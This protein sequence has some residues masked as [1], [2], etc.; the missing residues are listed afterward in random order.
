MITVYAAL[1][2]GGYVWAKYGLTPD[3]SSWDRVK[4][5]LVVRA[6]R[7]K[8]A[9]KI[10]QQNLD[11]VRAISRLEPGIRICTMAKMPQPITGE[12][13][14]RAEPA[15]AQRF[16]IHQFGETDCYSLPRRI[17]AMTRGLRLPCITATTH[18]GLAS[19]A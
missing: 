10:S 11:T 2:K 1:D 9:G 19:G 6:N 16:A 15:A 14:A 5:D 12:R 18:N 4:G 8:E 7:L 13:Y 3:V 17:A